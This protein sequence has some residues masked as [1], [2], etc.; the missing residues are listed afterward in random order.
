MS[1]AIASP[2]HEATAASALASLDT[3]GVRGGHAAVLEQTFGPAWRDLVREI[4][5]DLAD[6]VPM[7]TVVFEIRVLWVKRQ[8][9]W[10]DCARVLTRLVGPR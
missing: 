9:L 1:K 8:I 5:W 7:D 6:R 4:V 3:S 2:L 10:V